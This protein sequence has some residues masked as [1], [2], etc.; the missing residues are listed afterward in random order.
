MPTRCALD[1]VVVE[2][3]LVTESITTEKALENA[4]KDWRN[5]AE[6]SK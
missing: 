3:L 1:K 4:T 5:K 6:S 2:S